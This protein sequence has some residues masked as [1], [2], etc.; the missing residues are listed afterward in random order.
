MAEGIPSQAQV[1]GSG[2]ERVGLA[3]RI[4]VGEA[5]MPLTSPPW[6][7]PEAMHRE[8]AQRL[9]GGPAG[10]GEPAHLGVSRRDL[11]GSCAEHRSFA[12]VVLRYRTDGSR[13]TTMA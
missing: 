4:E 1:G 9:G 7:G 3:R 10:R 5:G 13:G 6:Q 2:P 8:R 11:V 12:K